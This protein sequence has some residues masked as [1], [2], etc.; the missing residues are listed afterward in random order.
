ME[1]VINF[2]WNPEADVWIAMSD[3]IYA[4]PDG[5][6]AELIDGQIYNMAPPLR[7][8]QDL[9]MNLSAIL[10]SILQIYSNS[11]QYKMVKIPIILSSHPSRYLNGCNPKYQHGLKQGE[12]HG[13][14]FNETE[15]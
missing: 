5:Q 11:I 2:T 4:L 9:I 10:T 14:I 13:R 15:S 6:R 7:I 8:H 1:Y 12:N 3:D